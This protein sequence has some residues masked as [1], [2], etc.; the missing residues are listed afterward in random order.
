MVQFDGLIFQFRIYH[1][2]QSWTTDSFGL[3]II[4]VLML[5]FLLLM[6]HQIPLMVGYHLGI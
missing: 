6:F 4:G 1:E 2:I 5:W 3:S